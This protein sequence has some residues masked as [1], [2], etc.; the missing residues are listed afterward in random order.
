MEQQIKHII[1][2]ETQYSLSH[3]R[4]FKLQYYVKKEHVNILILPNTK[5]T[6][7]LHKIHLTN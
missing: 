2:Y 3:I 7:Y 6:S 5:Q 4:K 1:R